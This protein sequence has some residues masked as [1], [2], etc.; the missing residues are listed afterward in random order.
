M[1]IAI[2]SFALSI[3][4]VTAFG[5]C[6]LITKEIDKFTDTE[7]VSSPFVFKADK[8]KLGSNVNVILGKVFAPAALIKKSDD[9]TYTM[10]FTLNGKP[11]SYIPKGLWL[12][13]SDGEKIQLPD[14]AIEERWSVGE[15]KSYTTAIPLDMDN[16]MPFLTKLI[17]DIKIGPTETTID[18]ILGDKLRVLFNCVVSETTKK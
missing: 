1:K 7:T 8:R 18:E 14:I 3:S 16:I 5:Q 15:L 11:V 6:D 2:I 13:F 4:N 9:S 12:I 17:T 10:L